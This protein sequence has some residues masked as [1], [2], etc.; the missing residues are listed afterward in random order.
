MLLGLRPRLP[1]PDIDYQGE[2]VLQ[3]ALLEAGTCMTMSRRSATAG[4]R[5]SGMPPLW[6]PV[7]RLQ[8]RRGCTQAMVDGSERLGRSSSACAKRA[9]LV[10]AGIHTSSSWRVIRWPR[11]GGS[12]PDGKDDKGLSHLSPFSLSMIP[13]PKPKLCIYCI[14]L[15][16]ASLRAEFGSVSAL[17]PVPDAR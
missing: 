2:D 7:A 17:S 6:R 4:A 13:L 9:C 16:W 15:V 3:V 8:A 5:S 10:W 1:Y 11:L 12:E 14:V